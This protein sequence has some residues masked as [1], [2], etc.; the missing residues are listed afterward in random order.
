MER[1]NTE[2]SLSEMDPTFMSVLAA[3][4]CGGAALVLFMR[5]CNRQR[6]KVKIRKARS[7]R[8]ASVQQ[9]EQ[10]VQQFSTTKP[11]AE[12]ARIVSLSLTELTKRLQEGSLSPEE[13]LHAYMEKALEV[14]KR[15]NCATDILLESR[16]QLSNIE[17]CRDGLLYGVPIS[18]KDNVGYKGHDSTCGVLCKVDEPAEEDCVVVTVLKRQGAIPFIKTNIPQGLLNYDCSNPLF[19]QSLNPHNLQKTPGGSSGGEG[20]LI[21]GGG[22][23]LGIG[24]DIGG[25]IRIPSSFCGICGFKPTSNRI[26]LRGLSSCCR[27]QKSVLSAVGPMA[28]DVDSLALCMKALLCEDMFALDPTVPPMPFDDKA[29]LSTKRLRIGYCENDGYLMPSPSMSRAFRE[30]RELLEKAGHTFVPFTPPRIA[31]AMHELIVKGLLADGAETLLS[32]LKGG[33]VDPCLMAQ[34][35]P[36]R[37]PHWL[38]KTLSVILRPILPRISASLSALCGVSSV[39]D[40][41]RQHASVE[42]YTHEFISEWQRLKMDVLLCPMLGPAFNLNYCGKLTCTVHP[43]PSTVPVDLFLSV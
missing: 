12:N 6:M 25:S 26:S 20:A 42:D 4:A 19:G 35:I 41:W 24:T 7:R 30:T 22:S 18:I 40:L 23:I 28:R 32:N 38:K 15:L 36:Y 10:A 2:F 16:E 11:D 1:T 14:N 39:P 13:A 29:Y 5:Y 27:G 8:D 43:P 9:A 34:I 21:G 33:P 37:L 31:Y 3:T 17:N